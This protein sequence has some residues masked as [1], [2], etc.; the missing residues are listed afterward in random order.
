MAN[1]KTIAKQLTELGFNS[2]EARVYVALT[3][4]GEANATNIAKKADLPRTTA[5][6]ILQK[7]EKEKWRNL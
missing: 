4:L 7:L 2:N 1:S 5:I 6:S 3:Q